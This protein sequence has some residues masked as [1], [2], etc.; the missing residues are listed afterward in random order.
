M[1][2]DRSFWTTLPGVLTGIAGLI[3]ATATLITALYTAGFFK[4]D[5]KAVPKGLPEG[6]AQVDERL[7]DKRW[8]CALNFESGGRGTLR[9]DKATADLFVAQWSLEIDTPFQR[10]MFRSAD[11]RDAFWFPQRQ[12]ITFYLVKEGQHVK[13]I[14]NVSARINSKDQTLSVSGLYKD[15]QRREQWTGVCR[16]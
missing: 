3:A 11:S 13:T 4:S 7:W 6:Q 2:E 12:Q 8:E 16:S 14:L 10:R 15:D 9:F 1:A 5:E